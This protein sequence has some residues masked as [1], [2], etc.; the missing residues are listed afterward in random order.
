MI[1]IY[2]FRFYYKM[3]IVFSLQSIENLSESWL[4]RLKNIFSNFPYKLYIMI[5]PYHLTSIIKYIDLYPDVSFL[6]CESSINDFDVVYKEYCKT[7]F[8]KYKNVVIYLLQ[9]ID[10]FDRELFLTCIRKKFSTKS[11]RYIENDY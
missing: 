8:H 2:R 7:V 10:E 3:D 6:L 11:I 1:V 5:R 9:N 4:N